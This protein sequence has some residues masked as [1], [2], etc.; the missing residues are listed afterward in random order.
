[1]RLTLEQIRKTVQPG[2]IVVVHYLHGGVVAAGIQFASKGTASHALC[3]LGG[4]EV[5]EALIGGVAHSY[6]DNYLRGECRLTIKRLRPNL[7]HGE[8]AKV[9]DYWRSCISHPYDLGMILHV[10]LV[11]PIKRVVLPIFPPLGRLLL[12]AVGHLPFASTTLST[13]AELGARGLRLARPKFL[14]AY[15]PED[16]TPEVLLRDATGLDTVVVWDAPVIVG[17]K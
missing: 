17:A 16:I 11:T 4:N 3:C 6:L 7:E 9:C 8:A 15:A 5:V 10:A 12:R 13:C 1:M 14:R 2:D